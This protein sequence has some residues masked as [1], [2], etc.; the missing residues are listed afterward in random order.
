LDC[1]PVFEGD[2]EAV[3]GVCPGV[4]VTWE[5]EFLD[6]KRVE[7]TGEISAG[8]HADAREGFF[9]GAGSA[10]SVAGFEDKDFFAR[11]GEIGGAGE[12]VVA[13]SDDDAVPGL[14]GKLFDWGGETKQPE[15]SDGGTGH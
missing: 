12:A 6:D 2:E 15:C 14:V 9:N 3:G 7:E 5:I 13:G 4:A 1:V 10:D 8:G 11:S